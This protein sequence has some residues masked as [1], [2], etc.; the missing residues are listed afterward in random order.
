MCRW[1]LGKRVES[2]EEVADNR[3]SRTLKVSLD[4]T[5]KALDASNKQLEHYKTKNQ[6]LAKVRTEV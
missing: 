3:K 2:S 6:E 4:N 5:T 1:H